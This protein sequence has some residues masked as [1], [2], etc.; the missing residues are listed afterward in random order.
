MISF[1]VTL[2][3]VLSLAWLAYHVIRKYSETD[4]TLWDRALAGFKDSATVLLAGATYVGGAA[5]NLVGKLADAA[6]APEVA[7]A[8]RMQIPAEYAGFGLMAMAVLIFIAR[9]RTL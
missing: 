2:L 6:N 7:E 4:G 8:V 1:V 3:V 5:V 9:L